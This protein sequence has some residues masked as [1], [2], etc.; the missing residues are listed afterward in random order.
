[1]SSVARGARASGGADGK[2]GEAG[3]VQRRKGLQEDLAA[4]TEYLDELLDS[5]PVKG[6]TRDV[7][8][9]LDAAKRDADDEGDGDERSGWSDSSRTATR[10]AGGACSGGAAAARRGRVCDG[11]HRRLPRID[12]R[13]RPAEA[14]RAR[15]RALARQGE[16]RR[17]DGGDDESDELMAPRVAR[18]LVFALD[19]RPAQASGRSSAPSSTRAGAARARATRHC[20]SSAR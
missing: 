4:E 18:Q 9:L 6:F 14:A 11:I 17:G 15:A 8:Q 3:G 20:A 12:A 5:L 13:A 7:F 1:M 2:G 19:D 16:E 10:R